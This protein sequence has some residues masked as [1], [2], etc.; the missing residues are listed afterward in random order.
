MG[1]T[2]MQDLRVVDHRQSLLDSRSSS[3]TRSVTC[4]HPT[5][6]PLPDQEDETIPHP[7]TECA[8]ARQICHQFL[9][10]WSLERICPQTRSLTL[11]TV[12]HFWMLRNDCVFNKALSD[13]A[14][15]V[16][17][18][19]TEANL[20]MQAGAKTLYRLPLHGRPPDVLA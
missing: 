5:A 17:G 20:W 12:W 6:C 15:L 1:A 10:R 14:S 11:L 18:I 19:C 16:E 7:L 9:N 3:S 13:T 4:P 2:Q 8:F